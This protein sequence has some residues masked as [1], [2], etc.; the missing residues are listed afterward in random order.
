MVKNPEE[1][2]DP[3]KNKNKPKLLKKNEF[4]SEFI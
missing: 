2:K 3:E 4:N 1:K